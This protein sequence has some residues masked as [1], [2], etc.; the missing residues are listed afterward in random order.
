MSQYRTL[1][2]REQIRDSGAGLR[3]PARVQKAVGGM[4]VIGPHE[5]WIRPD[6]SRAARA[7]HGQRI[8][9]PE[10]TGTIR[11]PRSPGT[12]QRLPGPVCHAIL[13]EFS[14]VPEGSPGIPNDSPGIFQCAPGRSR[15]YP[16]VSGCGP[17]PPVSHHT[18]R[19]DPRKA[20]YNTTGQYKTARLWREKM[21]AK[22]LLLPPTVYG[23]DP[24]IRPVDRA[25]GA[26]PPHDHAQPR[27]H[28]HRR[29]RQRHVTPEVWPTLA[30]SGTLE[31]VFRS[32]AG[33]R[34]RPRWPQLPRR[35]RR[36][37]RSL[38]KPSVESYA[39]A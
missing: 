1:N 39:I 28:M 21:R 20:T 35:C 37:A 30:G 16:T 8:M 11:Y 32:N 38:Q 36:Q 18:M 23:A 17:D 6:T 12:H 2:P 19:R 29:G 15:M 34:D 13:P 22:D 5:G 33:G 4:F 7:V 26:P 9:R 31:R 3:R 10:H 27:R 14:K 25:N 24:R